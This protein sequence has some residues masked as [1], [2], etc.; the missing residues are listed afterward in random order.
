M[1]QSLYIYP[2]KNCK[3][4]VQI[5]GIKVKLGIDL[6]GLGSVNPKTSS[7]EEIKEV[8][9]T[10]ITSTTSECYKTIHT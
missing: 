10:S 8:K 1:L 6:N 4:Y 2:I 5:V 9:L 7:P 3:Q